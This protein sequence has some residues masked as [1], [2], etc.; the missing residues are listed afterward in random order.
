[1]WRR[2][3]PVLGAALFAASAWVVLRE[4]R[5]LGLH[6]VASSLALVHG[7]SLAAAV[8]LTTINYLVLTWHDWLALRYAGLK[9]PWRRAGLASFVG[10]PVSNNVGFALV[11]GTSAR[12]RFYSRWG[13]TTASLSRVVLFYSITFWI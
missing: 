13:L 7:R 1:M 12:Y 3:M 5:Q 10:Y 9:L 6:T 4:I 11:S 8:L 2:L